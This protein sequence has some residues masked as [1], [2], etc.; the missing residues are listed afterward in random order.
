MRSFSV[1]D[2]N[3][4]RSPIALT[5]S[6]RVAPL[7]FFPIG[8]PSVCCHPVANFVRQQL[9]LGNNSSEAMRWEKVVDVRQVGYSRLDERTQTPRGVSNGIGSEGP[10]TNLG[11]G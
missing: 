11:H 7:I 1:L 5:N 8:P 3:P 6:I 10:P 2:P 9:P 4:Y